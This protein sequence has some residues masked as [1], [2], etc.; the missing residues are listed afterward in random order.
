[1]NKIDS[2]RIRKIIATLTLASIAVTSSYG[3]TRSLSQKV[4]ARKQTSLLDVLTQIESR[5]PARF[6]Y[7]ETWLT[8]FT[9]SRDYENVNLRDLLDE[10]LQGSD[11]NFVELYDYAV[12][13]FK[14]AS[15]SI[16]RDSLIQSARLKSTLVE[17][18]SVGSR[19][20]FIPGS[21]VTI[22]GMIRDGNENNP[23]PG[24]SVFVDEL[25]TGF[26]ADSE[27]KFVLVLPAGE[28]LLAIRYANYPEKLIQ[29]TAHESGTINITMVGESILLEEVVVGG[30]SLLKTTIGQVRLN[31]QDLQRSPTFLGE[32]DIIKQIQTQSGVTTVSEASSGF[33][34]RGGSV[35]QNLVLFDGTPIFNTAHALGFFTAFN[36]NAI[37]ETSFYKGA[38]P[39]EYGGRV[40]SVL[41][42]GSKEGNFSKWEGEGGI[43]LVS[44]HLYTG[45]PLKKGKQSLSVS[46]RSSYSDWMLNLLKTRYRGISEGSVFFYDA[47]V[48]Y[49][50]RL[51]ETSKITASVY[52]SN[53]RFS[54]ASDTVNQWNNLAASVRYDKNIN[55]QFFYS[56]GLHLGQYEFSLQDDDPLT[57]FDLNYK[58]LYP[59]L[60]L[61][62]NRTAIHRQSFGIHITAYNF[63]PGTMVPTSAESQIQGIT[64]PAERSIESA[65]Y[66]TDN[67]SINEKIEVEAG[68]RISMYN[69]FGPGF[70]Y[71]YRDER[72]LE[73]QYLTDSISYNNSQVIKTFVRP[74]PRVA[75]NFLIDPK[76]TV[77]FGYN[78]MH[79]YLHLITNTATVT[80]VDIW[81]S[82]NGYF[83]PQRSD[84]F[85]L[86]YFRKTK[87]NA[88]ELSVETFYKWQEN[89]LEFKDGAQLI[90]NRYIETSLLNGKA[91]A[92]G[93][94]FSLNKITGRTT[95][96]FNYTFSRSHRKVAGNYPTEILNNGDWFPSNMDQPHVV[97]LGWRY[98][99]TRRIFFSGTFTYHTGRPV[100]IPTASYSVDGNLIMDFDERNNY[101]I[102]DYHRMDLSVILEGTNRKNKRIES[103]WLFSIYNVYARKNPYSVFFANVSGAFLKPYQLSLIGTAVPSLSYQ[104][105]F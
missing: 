32:T 21:K 98:D 22:S 38:V 102:P 28:Y 96:S 74:E 75:V 42:I 55:E 85:S 45:G 53:D 61:D 103:S 91:R 89:I 84:Q 81:Q 46:L 17:S 88:L 24:A 51:S 95:G 44:S 90:L 41:N 14:D 79:Q 68:L 87:D 12:I 35:D 66:F 73:T 16:R 4:T 92:Y 10:E 54:I 77:K 33:N 5:D 19:S 39:A 8:P 27:G 26:S 23:L 64:I 76:S 56:V 71:N 72:P 29:L 78:R 20:N 6:F 37:Q 82:S 62:F 48:K 25:N 40:S 86:G 2:F 50:A 105:K 57:A 69:R 13:F 7:L 30:Q 18:I 94:E 15:P 65:I 97:N 11:I 70:V 36:S 101:R 83:R 9:V 1:M 100:S 93:I 3:Q 99:I 59:S 43:G 80:P 47:N 58:I 49:A 52:T 34:V 67:F 31:L 104:I 60:K 63:E